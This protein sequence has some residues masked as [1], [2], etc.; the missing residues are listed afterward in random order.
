[1]IEM[2]TFLFRFLELRYSRSC[3]RQRLQ[4]RI[5]II[6][7]SSLDT[8]KRCA[9]SAS[10]SQTCLRTY[11]SAFF[12]LRVKVRGYYR[13]H[14]QL[15]LIETQH[16][17]YCASKNRYYA[18]K[19]HTWAFICYLLWNSNAEPRLYECLSYNSQQIL[20]RRYWRSCND[21]NDYYLFKVAELSLT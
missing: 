8:E 3:C 6:V 18:Y 16:T 9:M 7:F 1:M 2:A 19:L 12:C 20:L 4:K 14:F 15:G 21:I 10:S 13:P 17:I 11:F 5:R